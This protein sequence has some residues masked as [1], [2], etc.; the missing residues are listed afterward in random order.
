MSGINKIILIGNVEGKSI[1]YKHSKGERTIILTV[2]TSERWTDKESGK[3]RENTA[4][5]VPAPA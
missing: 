4:V 1:F 5:S 2:S 3:I